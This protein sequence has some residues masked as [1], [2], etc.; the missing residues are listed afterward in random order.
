LRD[1]A[2]QLWVGTWGGAAV[3]SGTG[4]RVLR[5]AD[6]LL[7]DMVNVI[8]QDSQGGMWFGSA[9][10]P[11]GGLSILARGQW[12]YLSRSEGLPHNNIQALG[13][14]QNGAVWVGSGLLDRGGTAQLTQSGGAW[15]VNAVYDG[16]NGLAGNKGRSLLVDGT[17]KLWIGSEYDGLAHQTAAG[18]E[19]FTTVDGLSNNEIKVIKQ[20]QQGNIWL[21]TRDGLTRI[22]RTA[23]AP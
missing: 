6:G 14:D 10:A 15:R 16:H 11:Q 2:G 19:I 9:V 23:L 20:D 5:A 13:Q 22:N 3:Q 4:W 1:R 8:M 21:G 12:Q 17:G 18:W 7:V